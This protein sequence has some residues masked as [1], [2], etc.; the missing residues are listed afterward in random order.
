M[1]NLKPEETSPWHSQMPVPGDFPGIVPSRQVPGWETNC[2]WEPVSEDGHVPTRPAGEHPPRAQG[3]DTGAGGRQWAAMGGAE[4]L[5]RQPTV[6]GVTAE[7]AVHVGRTIGSV[8]EGASP[9]AQPEPVVTHGT[10]GLGSR[11]Q[12][13]AWRLRFT[14]PV[15]PLR[16]AAAPTAAAP[17][18]NPRAAEAAIT[19]PWRRTGS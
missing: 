19:V 14:G 17:S 13:S 2:D 3:R 12:R 18:A 5:S 11:A 7:A 8:C 4:A 15:G 10:R 6:H 1:K 16:A 9:G